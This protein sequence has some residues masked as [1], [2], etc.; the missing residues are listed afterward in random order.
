MRQLDLVFT[1]KLAFHVHGS[2]QH[3]CLLFND[4]AQNNHHAFSFFS[5]ISCTNYNKAYI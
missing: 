5:L 4:Y 3:I 2:S 1:L